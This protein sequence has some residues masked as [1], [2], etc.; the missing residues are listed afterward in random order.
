MKKYKKITACFVL[1]YIALAFLLHVLFAGIHTAQSG[2]YR[3]S[4]F[5]LA[6]QFA[7]QLSAQPPQT[8]PSDREDAASEHEST[9]SQNAASAENVDKNVLAQLYPAAEHCPEIKSVWYMNAAVTD[10][11]VITDFYAV[12]N[13]TQM[14]IV[15]VQAAQD[16]GTASADTAA[17]LGYLRFNYVSNVSPAAYEWT[18]QLALA[19]VFVTALGIILYIYIR[20]IKPFHALTDMPYELSRGHLTQKLPESKDR[21]F[22]RFVWGISM[23]ADTLDSQRRRELQLLRERKMLLLSISHD[24][25]TPLGSLLLYAKAL[26]EGLYQEPSQQRE[27]AV[28]IQ[29]KASEIDRFVQEIVRAQTEEMIAV[30]VVITEWYLAG[31]T[32]KIRTAYTEKCSVRQVHF[33]VGAYENVLVKGD[34]DRLYESVGNLMENALKYGDGSRI[35]VSF[36]E[37]E[38][39]LLIHVYNSG[40]P[41][42][43]QEMPHLFDSFFRGSNA[44]GREGSGLGLYIC[45]EIMKKMQGEAYAVR[46]EDGMEFVLVCRLC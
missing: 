30:E 8:Q 37:E 45:S 41:V 3:V 25:K 7:A 9:I 27:A 23:L 21:Y 36:S 17:V 18:A 42:S 15:P 39:C 10:A 11:A 12:Q 13:D 32:E 20:I 31:L 38:G 26:E 5:R 2:Q 1:V 35:T 40:T 14:L 22:G 16:G 4:A 34:F 6:G 24:I 28:R 44:E 29:E 33:S 43:V 19:M 46:Y